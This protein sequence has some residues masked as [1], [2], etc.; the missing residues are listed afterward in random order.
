MLTIEPSHQDYTVDTHLP[1]L[2]K[3]EL[4]LLPESART[5]LIAILPGLNELL[6]LRK[7]AAN[8]TNTD[9]EAGCNP[10][11]DLP[12]FDCTADSEIGTCSEDIAHRI[13]LLQDTRHQTASI[14]RAIF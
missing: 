3:H 12:G 6:G 9:R 11:N 1:L 14:C 10:E 7:T 13:S 5:T 4:G 2:N 8:K